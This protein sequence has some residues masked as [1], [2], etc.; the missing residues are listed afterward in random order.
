MEEA[1]KRVIGLPIKV[2]D[3]KEHKE[4]LKIVN[5]NEV[6]KPDKRIL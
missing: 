1:R 5:S 6:G 3:S 2:D 4:V